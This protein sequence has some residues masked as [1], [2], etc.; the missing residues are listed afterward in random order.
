MKFHRNSPHEEESD[1]DGDKRMVNK[2]GRRGRYKVRWRWWRPTLTPNE[3]FTSSP[4]PSPQ[5]S[6]L[7]PE[8]SGSSVDILSDGGSS[9]SEEDYQI[10]H[11]VSLIK[12]PLSPDNYSDSGISLSDSIEPGTKL[13]PRLAMPYIGAE[14]EGNRPSWRNI[15]PASIVQFPRPCVNPDKEFKIRTVHFTVPLEHH[16]PSG[17]QINIHAELV[18]DTHERNRFDSWVPACRASPILVFLCGGPGDKN[19]HDRSPA[20][21]R[22]LIEKG[23]V[24]LYADYRGT[25]QS[26]KIDSATVK[27]YNDT[28][29]FAGAA[30]YL[31][32]FRQDNIVRD[33]EAVRLCLEEH[34]Y[35]F[36]S[37][38]G[39]GG[40]GLKWT[41]MGQSYGG[42]VALTYLSFLPGSLAE[43]YLTAGLAPVTIG[44]P[45]EVYEALYSGIRRSNQRYYQRYPE[46]E[47][48]VREVYNT[49]LSR[50]AAYELPDGS[51]RKLTAQTFLTL[52]RKF[53]GGDSGLE[54][55]HDFVGQLHGQL[56]RNNALVPSPE[57]L[58]EFSKLEGFKLHSRPLYGVLHE[59]IYCNNGD[60]ASEWSAQRVGKRHREYKGWLQGKH[61]AEGQRLYFS[62]EMVLPCLMP[63]EFRYANDLVAS[64]ADWEPLYDLNRLKENTVP[65]RAMA[66][67]DDLA[68]DFELS[69]RT[70]EAVKGCVMVVGKSGWNHGSLRNNT[71][72]VIR[73]L[74]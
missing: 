46:D 63:E 26:S 41:L 58:K 13:E 74:F 5:R 3:P 14:A 36:S 61:A 35:P 15:R 72:E 1:K 54:A 50:G 9:Q 37:T 11:S 52:G 10:K 49:L 42:W 56:V 8:Y 62:G 64:K 32:L 45:D 29:D 60:T 53:I 34:L 70:V 4:S 23:Y 69:K 24:V 30:S 19:P 21:N 67:Q 28:R 2:E 25:G 55:V 47:V 48:L 22:M 39:N 16:K 12:A 27:T 33:L 73:M 68:V 43:V 44:S 71:D 18:Y 59:A 31:S 38:N 66:Y 40:D 7:N 6:S 57:V 65:V 17:R 20:L 51:K